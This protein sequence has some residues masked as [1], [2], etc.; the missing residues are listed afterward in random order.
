MSNKEGKYQLPTNSPTLVFLPHCPLDLAESLLA[1]NW[2][3]STISN[4]LFF[5]CPVTFRNEGD[6]LFLPRLTLLAPYRHSIRIPKEE[7]D[8]EAMRVEWF[9]LRGASS[10]LF[11]KSRILPP[12]SVR[13]SDVLSSNFVTA[14]VDDADISSEIFGCLWNSI[15]RHFKLQI[16]IE[17]KSFDVFLHVI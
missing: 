9:D 11:D 15:F 7:T 5:S 16:N 6:K 14:F 17:R 8:F 13:I 1:A 2:S 10:V 3:H 12:T 4:I